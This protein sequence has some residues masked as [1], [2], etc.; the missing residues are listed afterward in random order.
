MHAEQDAIKQRKTDRTGID[1]AQDR[2]PGLA[3]GIGILNRG[4]LLARIAGGKPPE[5]QDVVL[6]G[7]VV[8]RWNLGI[9]Q[10]G[11]MQ[12]DQ[13]HAAQRV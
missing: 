12:I 13:L 3:P 8:V 5:N 2:C 4:L 6:V 9:E 7:I 10:V 1:L 11:N